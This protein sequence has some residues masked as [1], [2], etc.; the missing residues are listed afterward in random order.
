MKTTG[1]LLIRPTTDLLRAAGLKNISKNG[2][3]TLEENYAT[4][5]DLVYNKALNIA[6]DKSISFV[7]DNIVRSALVQLK[8]PL[9]HTKSFSKRSPMQCKPFSKRRSDFS[10]GLLYRRARINFYNQLRHC[11]LGSHWRFLNIINNKYDTDLFTDAALNVLHRGV[12]Q[13]FKRYFQILAY[14]AL[15]SGNIT[16]DISK[17]VFSDFKKILETRSSDVSSNAILDVSSTTSSDTVSDASSDV[18]SDMVP[19]DMV[20][21]APSIASSTISK[22]EV[23]SPESVE[24]S[25]EAPVLTTIDLVSGSDFDSDTLSES[26][27]PEQTKLETIVGQQNELPEKKVLEPSLTVLEPITTKPGEQKVLEPYVSKPTVSE[28][29]VTEPS[30]SEPTVSEPTVSEPTVTEP[31]VSEPTVPEPSVSEPTVPEPSVSE[32]TVPKPSVSELTVIEPSVS[33]LIV[34]EPSVS[35]PTVPEPSV[36]E[37]TVPKPSVSELTV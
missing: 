33:E 30:V 26:T 7:T 36:S 23:T 4:I 16:S 2:M 6:R 24:M 29:T 32:P 31:S 21:S 25:M 1:F 13:F 3:I 8:A 15:S 34:R 9:L 28:L 14:K 11:T 19:D 5:V 10:S 35:E 17:S 22:Q 20:S 18:S 27:V 12:D 37:P